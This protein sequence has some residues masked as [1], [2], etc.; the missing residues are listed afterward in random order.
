MN[1]YNQFSKNNNKENNKDTK[2]ILQEFS[3]QL[4]NAQYKND[5]YYNNSKRFYFR[6]EIQNTHI[7][8]MLKKKVD[9]ELDNTKAKVIKTNNIKTLNFF[10]TPKLCKSHSVHSPEKNIKNTSNRSYSKNN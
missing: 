5:H 6:K 7:K 10:V 8:F 1:S 3:Q 4:D 2:D 9:L